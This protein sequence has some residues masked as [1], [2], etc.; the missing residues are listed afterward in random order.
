MAHR[1]NRF[2]IQT[3]PPLASYVCGRAGCGRTATSET[4]QGWRSVPLKAGKG[5]ALICSDECEIAGYASAWLRKPGE[6]QAAAFKPSLK[7]RKPRR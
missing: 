1:R 4:M 2:Q 7:K 6:A 5:E 3:P